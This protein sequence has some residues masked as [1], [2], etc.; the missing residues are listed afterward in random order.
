MRVGGEYS[1]LKH[2]VVSVLEMGELGDGKTA[3][4]HKKP[5][6]LVHEMKV[7]TSVGKHEKQACG[8][9]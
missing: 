3:G 7:I 1:R 9:N 8:P 6:H 5:E 2:S 4:Q